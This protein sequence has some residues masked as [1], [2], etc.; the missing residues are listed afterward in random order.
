MTDKVENLTSET[1]QSKYVKEETPREN[2]LTELNSVEAKNRTGPRDN[3]LK[4]VTDGVKNRTKG[5]K[6]QQIEG[7]REDNED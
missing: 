4:A 5:P 3:G 7:G 2:Q 1:K 6:R